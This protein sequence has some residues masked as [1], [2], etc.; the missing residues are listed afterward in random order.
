MRQL[1]WLIILASPAFL[2]AEQDVRQVHRFG[3]FVG[4]NDGQSNQQRLRWAVADAQKMATIMA[5]TGGISRDD[6]TVLSQPRGADLLNTI[7]SM[8]S[9]I[10]ATR[11]RG[12]RVEFYF[13]YSGHSDEKGLRLGSDLV[14]YPDLRKAIT[15]SEA[16]VT[17]AIL[18]SC[19]SGAFTRAKG[20]QR[21][22]P[23]L[24]DLSSETSGYAFLTSSSDTEASQESDRLGGSFFTYYLVTGLRGAADTTGDKKVTL[25]QA[26]QYA[27]RETLAQTEG[28]DAGAQHASYDFQLKGSGDLVISDLTNPQ[29]SFVLDGPL[30][31]RLFIRDQRGALVSELRKEAGKALT[32]AVP[33]GSYVLRYERDGVLLTAKVTV[34]AN[35][36]LLV[37]QDNFVPEAASVNRLRGDDDQ[38]D[39]AVPR[40]L[41][42]FD[43]GVIPRSDP[44]PSQDTV[45][46]LGL[47][48]TRVAAVRGL[49]LSS[50]GSLTDETVDGFQGAAFFTGA[51][52]VHGVQAAG[53]VALAHNVDGVQLSLVNVST[54]LVRGTQIGLVNI[55]DDMEG[56]PIGLVTWVKNGIHEVSLGYESHSGGAFARWTSGGRLFWVSFEVGLPV[57]PGRTSGA[58]G[59]GWWSDTTLGVRLETRPVG[60]DLGMGL[61]KLGSRGGDWMADLESALGDDPPMVPHLDAFARWPLD[62]RF[63]FWAGP[64]FDLVDSRITDKSRYT[65]VPS[66]L[67]LFDLPWSGGTDSV[68]LG[69]SVGVSFR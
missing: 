14:L 69:V 9:V 52:E 17:V 22:Q 1:L 4:A 49:Q 55:A 20:G 12:Q 38:P 28:T 21:V 39:S 16:D 64:T 34:P 41:V 54:G 58:A 3:L 30:A 42:W 37:T 8:K 59:L 31:G 7:L 60:F 5:E 26:Y 24:S 67:P 51:G 13:Y 45:F 27:F 19:S 63:T 40:K 33:G 25:N 65:E 43:L 2:A 61:R 46:S 18:D 57:V 32:I 29:S 23:F 50:L 66:T 53:A 10:Q 6:Q 48:G 15:G 47:L 36:Q 56:I 68:F 62:E 44:S 11:A 35:R